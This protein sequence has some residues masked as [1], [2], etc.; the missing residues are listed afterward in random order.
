MSMNTN[1]AALRRL[2]EIAQRDTVHSQR[3]ADFLLAWW[4]AP[5]CGGFNLKHLHCAAVNDE[6]ANCMMTI[7]KYIARGGFSAHSLGY[8]ADA[9]GFNENFESIAR[10]W[11]PNFKLTLYRDRGEKWWHISDDGSRGG[12]SIE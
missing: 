7:V 11:R 8:D 2:I 1:E 10:K 9:D 12:F 3:V 5:D 6:I 4:N